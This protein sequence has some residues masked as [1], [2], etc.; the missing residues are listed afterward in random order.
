MNWGGRIGIKIEGRIRI[1]KESDGSITLDSTVIFT[2][3]I[4]LLRGG[5][6][7]IHILPG[8]RVLLGKLLKLKTVFVN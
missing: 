3:L 1:R 5:G 4:D 6:F 2:H 7:G 8:L